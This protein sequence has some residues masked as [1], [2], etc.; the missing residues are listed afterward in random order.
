MLN[1]RIT[2]LNKPTFNANK[3]QIIDDLKDKEEY[4]YVH[5]DSH[6]CR[7]HEHSL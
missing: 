6:F 5:I 1:N 7:A 2:R 4:P 3:K